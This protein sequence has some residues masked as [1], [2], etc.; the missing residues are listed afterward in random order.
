MPTYGVGEYIGDALGCLMMQSYDNFEVIIVDDCSPDNSADIA[1]SFINRDDRFLYIKHP[2]NQCFS[3]ARNTGIE[4][5]TGDYIL[6]LYPDPDTSAS[7]LRRLY[8]HMSSSHQ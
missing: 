4:H 6:F 2:E 3:A 5:A 1:R 8:L 7:F